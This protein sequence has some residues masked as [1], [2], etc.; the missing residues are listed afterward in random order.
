M[1]SKLENLAEMLFRDQYVQMEDLSTDE[2]REIA[3]KSL[4]AAS[5]FYDE[6]SKMKTFCAESVNAELKRTGDNSFQRKSTIRQR[7]WGVS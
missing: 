2:I 7:G 5:V 4:Q 1:D 3:I 6:C